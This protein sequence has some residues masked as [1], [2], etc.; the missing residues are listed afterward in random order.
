[1]KINVTNIPEEGLKVQFYKDENWSK[2]IFEEKETCG[3]HLGGVEISLALK[4]MRETFYLQGDLR[5]DAH[6]ECSRCLEVTRLPISASFK[7]VLLPA[8]TE[9]PDEQE[10]SVED[11][12][13]VQYR[14][15]L[16]DLD[17]LLIEQILLQIPMKVLCRED[18]K[19]LCPHC[20]I[21]LNQNSCQCHDE[22]LDSRLAILKKL[23][24]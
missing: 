12:D 19:G 24:V 15:D 20:G 11:L 5:T 22:H 23:K 9:H 18:C 16:I 8:Q 10:L 14:D 3:F 7:Y 21:N 17:P 2:Q 13:V 6:T 1:M 4:R